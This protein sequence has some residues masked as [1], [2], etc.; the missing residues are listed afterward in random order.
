MKFHDTTETYPPPS[1]MIPELSV[2]RVLAN[3]KNEIWSVQP[4]ALVFEAIQLMTERSIGA[5]LVMQEGR[6]EGIFSERDYLRRVILEDR[7]SRTTRIHE[8]MT[9]DVVTVGSYDTLQGCM[10]LMTTRRIRHLPVVDDDEV[11]G[12]ISIGDVVKASMAQQ[13]HLLD[14]LERYVS[15]AAGM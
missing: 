2:H 10:Q 9:R 1:A 11:V 6:L 4:E 13:R 7:T 8:I 12:V 5:V 15:R 14:E 3:K